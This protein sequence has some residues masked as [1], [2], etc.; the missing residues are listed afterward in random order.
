MKWTSPTSGW[1]VVLA[2]VGETPPPPAVGRLASLEDM[3]GQY[4]TEAEEQ[5]ASLLR[6]RPQVAYSTLSAVSA[7]QGQSQPQRG[8]KQ[9]PQGHQ[10]VK[11]CARSGGKD[12]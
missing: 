4:P 5:A 8:E 7:G 11:G 9:S 1:Q 2:L 6:P 10:E 3:A 12:M